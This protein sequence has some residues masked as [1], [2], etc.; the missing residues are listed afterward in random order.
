MHQVGTL[1][2]LAQGVHFMHCTTIVFELNCLL[3][4]PQTS[5]YLNCMYCSFE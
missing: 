4:C 1:I 5:L 2:E 3:W